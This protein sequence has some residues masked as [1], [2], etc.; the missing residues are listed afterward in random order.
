MIQYLLV[1]LVVIISGCSITKTVPSK[2]EYRLLSP[3]VTKI[4]SSPCESIT[5][6]LEPIQ[7]SNTLLDY[8]MYYTMDSIQ[9]RYYNESLWAQSPNKMIEQILKNVMIES[10]LF[11][12]VLDYRSNADTQWR[13][14]V[15]ILD[16]MQYFKD[17]GS[18]YVKLSMDF[19]VIKNIGMQVVASKHFEVVLPTETS[20]AQGGV[21]ALNK[22]V[23]QIVQESNSW[24][25]NECQNSL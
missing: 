5:I 21:V 22:A 23:S 16:C 3:D 25:Q 20:D 14:E 6:K 7:S 8:R 13:Y 12:S 11:A 9:Q 17:D 18:S 10:K 15:R 4:Q 24:L 2:T 1:V 19:V